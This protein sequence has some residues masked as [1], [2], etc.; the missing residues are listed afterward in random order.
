M[1]LTCL[2]SLR[3]AN[4]KMPNT[5]VLYSTCLCWAHVGHNAG[6][7]LM[8]WPT[9]GSNANFGARSGYPNAKW[10]CLGYTQM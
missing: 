3:D 4:V 10:L 6:K 2:T 7:V 5:L 9:Q 8:L 1:K